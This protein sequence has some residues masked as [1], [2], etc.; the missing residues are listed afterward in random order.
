[1]KSWL[2]PLIRPDFVGSWRLETCDNIVKQESD[3]DRAAVGRRDLAAFVKV[4][5]LYVRSLVLC[6]E[7]RLLEVAAGLRAVSAAWGLF[8]MS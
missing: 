7:K 1:M 2:E 8:H 3:A 4:E 6:E 5:A